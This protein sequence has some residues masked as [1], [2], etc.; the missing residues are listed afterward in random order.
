MPRFKKVYA[1][2]D[3]NKFFASL[4]PREAKAAANVYASANDVLAAASVRGLAIEW[5][6]VG[7]VDA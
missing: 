5:E 3:G 2:K 7:E 1:W 4:L 6:N